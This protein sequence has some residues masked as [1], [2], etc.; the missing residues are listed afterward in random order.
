ML[1]P[2][3][4]TWKMVKYAPNYVLMNMIGLA[5]TSRE[6]LKDGDV[7]ILRVVL[8]ILDSL[9]F[10]CDSTVTPLSTFCV[11]VNTICIWPYI[12]WQRATH[13]MDNITLIPLSDINGICAHLCC[14]VGKWVSDI[15]SKKYLEIIN[16]R[17][18]L[19]VQMKETQKKNQVWISCPRNKILFRP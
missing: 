15:N 16:I 17:F 7:P 2:S 18:I 11:E 8:I 19:S 5:H 13:V 10:N 1:F 12:Q 14:T 6:I 3:P 9:Q 4:S